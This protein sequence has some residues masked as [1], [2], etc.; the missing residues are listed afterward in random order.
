MKIK[1]FDLETAVEEYLTV[2]DSDDDTMVTLKENIKALRPAEKRIMLT[3]IHCGTYAETG[4]QFNVSGGCIK[5]YITNI[6]KKIVNG[7]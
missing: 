3:Y 4:R 2:T 6:K 1:E 7:L 5:S